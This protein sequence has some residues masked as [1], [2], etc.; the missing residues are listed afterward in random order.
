MSISVNTN[1]LESAADFTYMVRTV[2]YKNSDWLALYQNLRKARRR[3]GMVGKV[4]TKMGATTQELG[5]LYNETLQLVLLCGS[6][7]WVMM[8]AILKVL[9][10][11]H[12]WESRQIMGTT[13]HRTTSGE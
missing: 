7:S 6:D 11:F 13:T 4:V 1:P 3:W 12:H 9:E 8:G 2:A 5:M 10:G